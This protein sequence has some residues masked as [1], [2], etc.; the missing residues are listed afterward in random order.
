M[1]IAILGTGGVGQAFA[2]RLIGLGHDLVMGTRNAT[3]KKADE[4]FALFLEKNPTMKL[5]NFSEAA[6]FGEIILNV[7]KGE[8]TLDALKDAGEKTLAGKILIDISNPLDFSKGMPPSLI[9]SLSNTTSLGEEIQKLFPLTMVVKTL[10]TM[11]NGIMIN[12]QL[13]GDGEHINY[14]C[15]NSAE[16][17]SNVIDLLK[18][19]G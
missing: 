12:P 17:K 14:I 13:I 1:K 19:F 15:G 9:S 7:T 6:D 8:N 18:E 2:K 4:K 16:A 5:L 3:D 10:N 11:W